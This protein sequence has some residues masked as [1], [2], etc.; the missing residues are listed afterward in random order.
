MTST[1]THSPTPWSYEYSPYTVRT[2][3]NGDAGKE[4]PAFEIF[5][6]EGIKILDTNEDLPAE[7]QETNAILATAAPGLLAVVQAGAE[8]R[9]KWR[10]QDGLGTI[11]SIEYMDRLDALDLDAL[12]PEAKK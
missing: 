9:R 1:I 8:L 2:T 10:N 6:A 3:G 11:D 7:I 12:I 4:L 5:D